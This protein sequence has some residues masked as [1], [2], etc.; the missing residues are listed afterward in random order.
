MKLNKIFGFVLFLHLGVIAVLLV[1]PGCRTTQAPTPTFE[2]NGTITRAS[3][4]VPDG[5]IP[6]VRVDS[7]DPSF[8]SGTDTGD[9][10]YAPINP[11]DFDAGIEPLTPIEPLPSVDIAGSSYET[12]TV[13]KGDSLWAISKRYNV[14]LNEL[15]EANGMNKN[16]VL[17]IGQQ[18]RIPSEGATQ[19][20]SVPSADAYQ[21]STFD[22]P[23]TEYTVVSGDTL[24]RIANRHNTTVSAIKA[25]NSKS[26]DLIR[27]GEKLM[28][29]GSG[30]AA[31][32]PAPA[33]AA[34]SVTAPT[35]TTSSVVSGDSRIHVV[36]AGEYPAT[37]A[38]MYGMTT[39]E[40]LA[41]NGITD[42]RTLQVGQK[43][44]VSASGE[45][46]N[47]DTRVETVSA[48]AASTAPAPVVAPAPA[49]GPVQIRVVEADPLIEG[50]AETMEEEALFEDAVEIPVIRVEG[51]QP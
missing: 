47:V 34:S 10:R 9:G 21:P 35:V 48:P 6:A 19:T 24:S 44:K 28:I 7:M 8:N 43:L 25:A 31:P 17:K 41:T 37:I 30:G 42:P 14:S 11:D 15:Y 1:Q 27:V 39:D 50:D 26:S 49:S 13:K 16:S 4:T 23:T 3:K 20:V 29:P 32:K 22:S 38:R 45:A 5:L 12:Y 40:L 2:Q 36:K 46:A 51:Q 18:I 33:P